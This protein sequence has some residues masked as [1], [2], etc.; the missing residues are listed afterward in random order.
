M[1]N[2][3]RPSWLAR[4]AALALALTVTSNVSAADIDIPYEKFVL[5][6]GLRVIVHE[7][8]KAPIVA[9]SIWYHVG[10][11]DEPQ[12]K[13][14]FAH[15]FEHLMFN[16]TEN[17]D[18][19][20]FRPLEDVGA[21]QLNGTTYFDRTNYFETVPTPALELALFLES[22]RMG[23]LLGAITQEKLDEQ[24]DVVKNEKRQ[25]DNQ[26]YGL[27]NYKM[28]EGI[29]PEGHPYR[30]SPIGSM[31]DLNNASLDDVKEWFKTR[32]G[33]NNAVLVLAGDIDAAT[34]KPLIEKYFGDIPPG[35]PLHR[36]REWVPRLDANVYET[37]QDRVPQ[38][39]LY[40]SWPAPATNN[41]QVQRL[42][43]AAAA[44]GSGK[45]SRL[46]KALVYDTQLATSVS[47]T[48]S[49]LEIA[50]NFDIEVTLNP[51]ADLDQAIEILDATIAEF[52]KTGPTNDEIERARTSIEAGVV[53]GLEQVGGF[54]GKATTLARGELYAGNPADYAVRLAR[55]NEATSKEVKAIAN[56]WLSQGYYQLVVSPY[57]DPSATSAG[58][59]RSSLPEPSGEANLSFP[60]IERATLS[61]GIEVALARR[62]TVPVVNV[63]VQFDAGYAADVGRKLGT[64]SFALAMLDEGTA[65]RTA[66]EISA[67]AERLG[68]SISAGSN[69]D[70]STASL[71]ALVDKLDPSLELFADVVRNPL[72]AEAEIERLRRRWLATIGQE[73]VQPVGL[74]L[75]ALPPLLYG[76]GHA[77]AIPFTGS[78]TEASITSLTREDLAEFHRQWIRPS[79]ATIYVAGDTDLERIVPLLEKHFGKWKDTIDSPPEKV[80]AQVPDQEGSRVFLINRPAAPQTLILAGHLAPPK[81]D[82]ANMAIETMNDA[83]GGQFT[84]RINMNLREDKGWAYG[85]YSI[86]YDARGQRP[87]LLYAP[88]QSDRTGDAIAEMQREVAEYT[89]ERPTTEEEVAR[90]VNNAVRS[91]PGQFETAGAVLGAMLSNARYGRPDDYVRT[92]VPRYQALETQAVREQAQRV[93][94]DK[95]ITWVIVGDLS[96]IQEQV[97]ALALGPVEV[98]EVSDL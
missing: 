89:G 66:L 4:L 87:W 28:L 6:N 95:P 82:P 40:R 69:L 30:W 98:L 71:S 14:G 56:D 19:E 50:G 91:L 21:T 59:D 81:G 55:L 86:L 5:D 75:R 20:F 26:P 39:R 78:G 1:S 22:D 47:A 93:L 23:H 31:E 11:K 68:A 10:S 57:G 51:D 2:A 17:Y 90:V 83:L 76:E 54:G 44:L 48:M 60:T 65:D 32:Y 49:E 80:V 41:P 74:A 64:S 35:P 72:F 46:Y 73:K 15:L 97:E 79:N 94:K 43:L 70:V 52:L 62:S 77:Y 13:S 33:P 45:N 96:A 67:T 36:R 63:A 9:V 25:G 53:R 85:A 38:T 3:P 37:M 16:G 7:D 27:V 42:D 88:V 24:R 61:N 18:D 8:R 58:V 12:G 84:A 29:F 92:L 34:A